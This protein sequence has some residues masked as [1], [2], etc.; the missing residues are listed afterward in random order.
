M[1][2]TINEKVLH[3]IFILLGLYLLVSVFHDLPNGYKVGKNVATNV[4]FCDQNHP[5]RSLTENYTYNLGVKLVEEQSF[6]LSE[7][8]YAFGY[9]YGVAYGFG[10]CNKNK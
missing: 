1:T 9:G 4:Y 3:F 10:E 5:M 7:F 2:L 8:V 6:M